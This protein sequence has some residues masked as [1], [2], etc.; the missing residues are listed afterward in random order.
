MKKKLLRVSAVTAMALSLST[1]VAAA[2][3]GLI[4]H[5]GLDSHNE[6][7]SSSWESSR[8]KNNNN[9]GVTNNNPQHAHT[10]DAR[11]FHND[12]GGDAATGEAANDS[13]LR[14]NVKV[15]NGGSGASAAATAD[16]SGT[17]SN[18]GTDSYNKVSVSSS[19]SSQVT[20]NN[21]VSVTNNN[22]QS[23]HSGDASVHGNTTGGGATSGGASNISTNET[24]I[25]VTN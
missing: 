10:G 13:L 25:E 20:N 17:V 4:D 23:A 1:G 24:T 12:E 9:L 16:N 21:N 15:S 22:H 8:V 2:N 19:S 18:T 6:V 7:K 3:S 11:V 14:A 5:T